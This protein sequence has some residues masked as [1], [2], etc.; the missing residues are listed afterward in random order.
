MASAEWFVAASLLSSACAILQ[1]PSESPI[2]KLA[3]PIDLEF[4]NVEAGVALKRLSKA[5]GVNVEVPLHVPEGLLRIHLR[6]RSF[7]EALDEICRL[8]G[9][10]RYP[11]RVYYREGI[12]LE[13]G[14]WKEV[15]AWT[16][17]PFR[18]SV[19]DTARIREFRYPDRQDRTEIVLVLQWT[20]NFVPVRSDGHRPGTLRVTKVE[21]DTGRP[22]G[23]VG[24][25][26]YGATPWF[27]C[28]WDTRA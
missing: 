1:E 28:R 3:V 26:S 7:W 10:L 22:R 25:P 16:R 21:D 2:D 12:K 14:P 17:G 27:T 18:L 4:D 15:P 13:A 6:K 23:R 11:P 24:L 20:P 9:G 8:H 19:Y 5:A